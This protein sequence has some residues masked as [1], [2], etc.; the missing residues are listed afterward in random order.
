M[1]KGVSRTTLFNPVKDTAQTLS[2]STN[3]HTV[4]HLWCGSDAST[5]KFLLIF[6]SE[7]NT[8]FSA[9]HQ[10]FGDSKKQQFYVPTR[11]CEAASCNWTSKAFSVPVE[12]V[13]YK[14]RHWTED[15]L[16]IGLILLTN[17]VFYLEL[18][19]SVWT[20]PIITWIVIGVERFIRALAAAG[21]AWHPLITF[22]MQ[23]F[24]TMLW[25][26]LLRPKE[27]ITSQLP[28]VTYLFVIWH[29]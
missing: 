26:D 3:K 23:T 27:E 11:I 20:V 12:Q 24:P 9:V 4:I 5:Q 6:Y 2:T 13:L 8:F 10:S 16:I 18:Y 28:R 25:S 21:S 17:I 7:I 14:T 15:A 1:W 29:G 22:L 19:R